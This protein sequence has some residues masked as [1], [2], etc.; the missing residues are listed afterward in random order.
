ME[1]FHYYVYGREVTVHSDH[2]PLKA[3][4]KKPL[5]KASPRLQLMLLR[6]SKYSIDIEF[7]PGKY[8]HIADTLSRAYSDLAGSKH[9]EDEEMDLRVH[10]LVTQLP[11]SA[12]R[13]QQFREAIVQDEVLQAV[14]AFCKDG[15]PIHKW[16]LP[17]QVR[18]YWAIH[19]D[20]YEVEG[21]IFVGHKLLVPET[22]RGEMLDKIHQTHMGMEKC[23]ARAREILYWPGMTH[24]IEEIVKNCPTCAKFRRANPREPLHPHDV[25]SRPW[26]KLG[27]D[28][29]TL[30]G[31]DYLL[32]VDYYSKYPEVV[33]LPDKTGKTV[34]QKLKAIFARHGVPD[35]FMSDNMP[36]A[37]RHMVQFAQDWEF[38]LVTSS[39]TYARSNGQSER[40]VQTIKSLFKK[41]AEEQKCPYK[42]LLDYRN[43]PIVG[44]NSSPA[45]LLM[46]RRLKSNLPT[47]NEL[48]Q[49]SVVVG[50][51]SALQE[52]SKKQEH[53]YN[54]GTKPLPSLKPGET[55]RVRQGNL[56][57][58]ARVEEKHWTPRS[59]MVRT[60]DGQLYRRNRQ[61]LS[62]SHGPPVVIQHHADETEIPPPV[63]TSEN[64]PITP[65][66]PLVRNEPPNTPVVSLPATPKV[67]HSPVTQVQNTPPHTPGGPVIPKNCSPV[68]S[69]PKTRTSGRVV[70]QSVKLRDYVVYK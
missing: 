59:Y 1:K 56:W 11:L 22:L 30:D 38:D 47:H 36:F 24:D 16:Q 45:Q 7:V 69:A 68:V 17:V 41:A 44:L 37:S 58:P 52:R 29:F 62:T 4:I 61:H 18:P 43:T 12:G 27:A 70:R 6:L 55:V 13:V 66:T 39:P 51:K 54:R 48:L 67:N 5:H 28:I 8:M 46:S 23:K 14:I 49:P 33:T 32:V 35:T 65:P 15:W 34:V 57:Q 3:I 31:D 19:H 60:P 20:L 63:E 53:Y 2:Q 21:L 10:C 64:V 25:P 42:A 9:L 26:S 40:F 50:A